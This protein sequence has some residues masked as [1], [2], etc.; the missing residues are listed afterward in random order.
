MADPR[1]VPSLAG[2]SSVPLGVGQVPGL[3]SPEVRFVLAAMLVTEWGVDAA[4]DRSEVWNRA[5]VADHDRFCVGFRRGPTDRPGELVV[6]S[7]SAGRHGGPVAL[8]PGTVVFCASCVFDALTESLG[9]GARSVEV[10]AGL[11]VEVSVGRQGSPVFEVALVDLE[12]F[13]VEALSYRDGEGGGW[14]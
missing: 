13:V 5:G 8:S 4:P 9:L 1:L 14:F 2:G 12:P 7:H 3:A 6:V 11:V 10:L